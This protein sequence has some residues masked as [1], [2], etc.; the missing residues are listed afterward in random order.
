[1]AGGIENLVGD[2]ITRP[3]NAIKRPYKLVDII[4]ET[5]NVK[6]MRFKSE[7]GRRWTLSRDNSYR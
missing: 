4:Q 5:P 3:T 7:L 2:S 6:T 1:M